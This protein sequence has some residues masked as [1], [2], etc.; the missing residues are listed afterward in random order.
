[1]SKA[2]MPP[3]C[4]DVLDLSLMLSLLPYPRLHSKMLTLGGLPRLLTRQQ[5]TSSHGM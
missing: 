3:A 2:A 5:D 4:A 1:V